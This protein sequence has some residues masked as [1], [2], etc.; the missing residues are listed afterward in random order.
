MLTPPL[1]DKL[2]QLGLSGFRKALEEQMHSPHYTE[3]SFEE[4]LG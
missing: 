1:F 4:R 3:L 2:R